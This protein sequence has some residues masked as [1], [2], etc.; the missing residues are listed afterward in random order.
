MIGTDY[1]APAEH[2]ELNELS[3][4]WN[5]ALI[6]ETEQVY[7]AE[8]LAACVLHSAEQGFDQLTQDMLHAA[9]LQDGGLLQLVRRYATPRYQE[10]YDKGIHDVDACRIL[11]QLLPAHQASGLLRY[12]PETRALALAY[13]CFADIGETQKQNLQR[14]AQSAALLQQSLGS[15]KASRSLSDQVASQLA[16]VKTVTGLS[17]VDDAVAGD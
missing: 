9:L 15:R 4:F 8:Y 14:L 3:E 12:T 10:G 5:Q 17:S 6:S 2:P 13:W 11:E 7:R 16:D 1:Y